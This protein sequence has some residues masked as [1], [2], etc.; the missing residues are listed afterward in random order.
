MYFLRGPVGPTGDPNLSGAQGRNQLQSCFGLLVVHLL[1][2]SGLVIN[3]MALMT[4]QITHCHAGCHDVFKKSFLTDIYRIYCPPHI[5][6][7]DLMLDLKF[8]SILMKLLL[9]KN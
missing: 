1:C 5:S 2:P 9:R 4:G 8:L 6:R 7:C 3:Y